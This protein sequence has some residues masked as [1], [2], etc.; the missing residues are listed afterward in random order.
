MMAAICEIYRFLG[1]SALAMDLFS[2][3]LKQRPQ[4]MFPRPLI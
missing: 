3:S 4:T 2:L 1:K